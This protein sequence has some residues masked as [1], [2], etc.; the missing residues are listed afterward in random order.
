MKMIIYGIGKGYFDTSKLIE[1]IVIEKK[2]EVRGLADSSEKVQGKK[3]TFGG[4]IFNISNI[5]DFQMENDDYIL[6]TTDK[7]FFDIKE[8]L[9]KRGYEERQ[10]LSSEWIWENYLDKRYHINNYI[11]KSGIEIGGPSDVF[12]NIYKKC[13]LCDGVNFSSNTI[14]EKYENNDY[15]YRGRVLGSFIVAEATNLSIVESEKYDFILSS[16]NLEHIAN[17]LKALKEFA[18]IVKTKGFILILV[19]IKEKMFDHDRDYTTFEHLLEDYLNNIG[20]EDLTHLPEIIEKHDYEMDVLC[21]GKQ[22]FIERA[23]KNI[24]NRCLH[25]HVFNEECLRKAF[26]YVKVNVIDFGKIFNNWIIIGQK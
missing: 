20:E 13:A 7:Y 10:I 8:L 14:W 21:G 5:N 15:K 17:P 22:K 1:K 23:N 3:I 9:M 11:G 24:E 19:P 6:I 12:F 2:I 26:E 4:H 25:H 16:N 18:R